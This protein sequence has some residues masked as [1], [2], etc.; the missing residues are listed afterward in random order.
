MIGGNDV[1]LMTGG[2]GNDGVIGNDGNDVIFGDAGNDGLLGGNGNDV[3]NGGDDNDAM[4]GGDGNDILT[5]DAGSDV[6]F[7]ESSDDVLIGGLNQD[8]LIGGVGADKF[9]FNDLAGDID[10]IKD[11]TVADDTINVSAAGFGGG[12]MAGAAIETD[13]FIIGTAAVDS[14][15]RFIYNSVNGGLFFDVDG[16]G[17]TAQVQFAQ[18]L[19]GLALTNNDIFVV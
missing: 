16:V 18:L 2:D 7:G 11:F 14:S 8:I 19:P 15:D 12:L 10:F 3:M 17:G 9:V 6:L 13:Q 4:F 5:G 1:D